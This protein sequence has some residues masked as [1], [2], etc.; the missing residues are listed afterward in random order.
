MWYWSGKAGRRYNNSIT[1]SAKS[2]SLIGIF[3][4]SL[5]AGGPAEAAVIL[6]G[7]ERPPRNNRLALSPATG[8]N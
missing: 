8:Y 2:P 3:N 5:T 4:L 6:P 7:D 1:P